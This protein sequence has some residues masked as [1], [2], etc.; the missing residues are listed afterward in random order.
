[1]IGQVVYTAY[2]VPGAPPPTGD[3]RLQRRSRRVVGV[4]Q[5]GRD[6]SQ[7]RRVR[8]RRATARR[9]RPSC[10]TIRTPGSTSPISSSSTRSAPAS[11]AAWSTPDETKKDFYDAKTDIE[12]LSRVVYDW[13]IKNGR[14]TSRKYLI[15]ESYGGYRV[16]RLAYYLQSQMGVGVS[17]MVMV[18]PYLDPAA[19]GER[20]QR[21][22]RFRG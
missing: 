17:G 15:G 16:P 7:A 18:S 20:D 4:P 3:L 19:I 9:I 13:L 14:L 11:R 21:F 6:R 5:H 1:M 12:Y 22:R 2:I 8:S 10:A